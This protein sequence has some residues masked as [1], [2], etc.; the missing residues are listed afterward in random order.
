MIA[1]T[2]RYVTVK[3]EDT[4]QFSVDEPFPDGADFDA[5]TRKAGKKMAKFLRASKV[6]LSQ[7]YAPPRPD[8]QPWMTVDIKPAGPLKSARII[9]IYDAIKDMRILR[10]DVLW[11]PTA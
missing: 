2:Q 1:D 8:P 7:V 5:V 4:K 11:C 6:P 10:C 9:T 3:L